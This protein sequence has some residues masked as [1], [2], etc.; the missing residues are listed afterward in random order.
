MADSTF[1]IS[2]LGG[3]AVEQFTAIVNRPGSAILA[4][5]QVKERP[6]AWEGSVVIR[7]LMKLTLSSDH[8]VI[9]GAVA[10]AFLSDLRDRLERAAF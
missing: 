8:R 7:S 2:N 4:V 3:F 6:V 1:T 5:G 9:D 10:A